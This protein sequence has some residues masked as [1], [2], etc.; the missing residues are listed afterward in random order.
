MKYPLDATVEFAADYIFRVDGGG[1][2]GI[3][4]LTI[5]H[6]VMKRVQVQKGLAE[7]PK[8]CDYFHLMGGTSTGG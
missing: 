1:I 5:L 8:P 6:E 3:S 2:R 4:E 7:L